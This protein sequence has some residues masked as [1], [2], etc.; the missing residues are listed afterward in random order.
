MPSAFFY[1]SVILSFPWLSASPFSLFSAS[2]F[3]FSSSLHPHSLTPLFMWFMHHDDTKKM[4]IEREKEHFHKL[5][6]SLVLVS[7]IRDSTD[8][9]VHVLPDECDLYSVLTSGMCHTHTTKVGDNAESEHNI[10]QG[11]K[12]YL[13]RKRQNM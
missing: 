3:T 9:R 7:G 8:W 10:I 13:E 11:E 12:A 4:R 6:L 2:P 1:L 5:A